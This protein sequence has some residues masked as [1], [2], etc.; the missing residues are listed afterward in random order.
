M[1]CDIHKIDKTWYVN[2]YNEYYESW[3]ICG[4]TFKTKKAATSFATLKMLEEQL[5]ENIQE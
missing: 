4:E 3:F 2:M 5:Y 1:K